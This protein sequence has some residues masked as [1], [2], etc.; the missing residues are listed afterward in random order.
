MALF[1]FF[2]FFNAGGDVVSVA[3]LVRA[4]FFF[5]MASLGRALLLVTAAAIS[6]APVVLEMKTE[7][8]E[9]SQWSNILC[10]TIQYGGMFWIGPRFGLSSLISL[11]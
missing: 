11:A 8:K 6:I 5:F 9:R 7:R 3:V 1:F 10:G 2:F 4:F